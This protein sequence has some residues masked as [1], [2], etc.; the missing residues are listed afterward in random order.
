MIFNIFFLFL[1]GALLLILAIPIFL[2]RLLRGRPRT[3]DF[4]GTRNPFQGFTPRRDKSEGEV[5]VSGQDAMAGEKL[6]DRNIGEY[7][8][9]EEV[10]DKKK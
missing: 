2:V 6:V 5:T 4:R 9:Y 1:L 3:G 8:E 7:V 10:E